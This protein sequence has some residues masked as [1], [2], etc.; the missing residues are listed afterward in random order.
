M[1]DELITI[2]TI[3]LL[4]MLKFIAGPTLGFASGFS[5]LGTILLTIASM[6][7][8]VLLFTFLG[9]ILREKVLSKIFKRRKL[10][11]KRTRRF[12]KVWKRYGIIGVTC[13]TPIIFTPIGGTIL[14][15]SLG[16]PKRQII[17]WMLWWAVFWSVTF[18]STIYTFGTKILPDF[19]G[20]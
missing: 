18:S 9:Q 8:S 6:M 20:V 17:L 16:T 2:L 1:L 13:L 4:A 5:L 19:I 7:S 14:L 15:V 10:F 11:T 3:Y 12:V